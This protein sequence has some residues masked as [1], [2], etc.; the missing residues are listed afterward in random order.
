MILK[1]SRGELS[2]TAHDICGKGLLGSE[3]GG[4]TSVGRVA[5]ATLS[6]S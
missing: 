5:S 2:D 4:W 1:P 6:A 3:S